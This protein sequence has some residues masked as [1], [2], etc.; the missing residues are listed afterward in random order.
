[1][2]FLGKGVFG[3]WLDFYW[4]VL[5]ESRGIK[6]IGHFWQ[7]EVVTRIYVS[8][9]GYQWWMY[10]FL[11]WAQCK[12][13]NWTTGQMSVA[14]ETN[15]NDVWSKLHVPFFKENTSDNFICK[16]IAICPRAISQQIK[17]AS[18]PQPPADEK[19]CKTKKYLTYFLLNHIIDFKSMMTSSNGNIFR[20]TGHL[21]GEFIGPRWIPRTKA[22]D[23]ELWYF[24]WSASE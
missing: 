18:H 2:Y 7:H 13:M 9:Y 5:H 16:K 22:S 21:C 19:K 10:I 4:N 14:L 23:A 24:L 20:V 3:F 12:T 11:L 6:L 15:F 8:E 17:K 1:M